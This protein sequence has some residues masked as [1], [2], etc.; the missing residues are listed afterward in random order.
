LG[1]C[2]HGE[3]GKETM[4]IAPLVSLEGSRL[5]DGLHF[6]K[7]V[8][9]LHGGYI[10]ERRHGLDELGHGVGRRWI[11]DGVGCRTQYWAT[12]KVICLVHNLVPEL[13]EHRVRGVSATVG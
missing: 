10:S 4:R 13:S 9:Q 5:L 12:S 8:G 1:H 3:G 2:P 11:W 6:R 7:V